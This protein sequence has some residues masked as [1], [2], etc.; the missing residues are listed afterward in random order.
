M[1]FGK[2]KNTHNANIPPGQHET[3]RFPVLH[4]GNVPYYRD[5]EEWTLTIDGLVDEKMTYTYQQ[6]LDMPQTRLQNDIH[7]VTGWS[8]LNNMWEGI[9]P[10]ELL[11]TVKIND[12][13]KFVI[14]HAEEEFSTNLP[15]QDFLHEK[16]LLAH[17]YEGKPLTPEHGFP[18]RAVVSHLYFWKSAKWLRRIEFVAEEQL[19]FWEKNGYHHYGDPWK[20]ERYSWS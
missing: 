5:L 9:T 16:T 6:L 11:S 2:P 10:K 14:L 18:L 1:Y 17:S 13:A 12:S 19:G 15:I 20:E 7:C 3:T 4:H 8:K